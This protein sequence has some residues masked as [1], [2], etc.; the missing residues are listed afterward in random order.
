MSA[1]C[2]L[3]SGDE[4]IFKL[5]QNHAYVSHPVL[6]RCS[7]VFFPPTFVHTLKLLNLLST[8]IF[9]QCSTEPIASTS[10][11]VEVSTAQNNAGDG[12]DQERGSADLS[13]SVGASNLHFIKK[14]VVID[15][16]LRI[17]S[18]QSSHLED[19]SCTSTDQ[20]FNYD[21]Y[22]QVLKEGIQHT[23][24]QLASTLG[25]ASKSGSLIDDIT[26]RIVCERESQISFDNFPY[27][28]RYR[29]SRLVMPLSHYTIIYTIFYDTLSF[30]SLLL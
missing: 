22:V 13:T 14:I 6:E 16:L 1:S 4:L 8:Q 12:L 15:L 2:V 18:S 27:Y 23:Y 7:L 5:A 3:Q 30:P 10:P 9:L 25:L 26:S 20:I 24:P 21:I 28:L 19:K 29:L 17:P 11:S